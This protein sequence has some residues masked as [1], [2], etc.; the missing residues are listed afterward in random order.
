MGTV[1]ILIHSST[2][3]V[4]AK[5]KGSYL[6]DNAHILGTLYI[7][8]MKSL[9]YRWKINILYI[10]TKINRQYWLVLY[11]KTFYQHQKNINNL[12]LVVV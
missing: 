10:S 11:K 4:V 6:F 3:W 5:F 8:Y 9:S 1:D 12:H 7:V 2:T